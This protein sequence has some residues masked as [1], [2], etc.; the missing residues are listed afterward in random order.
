M[1]HIMRI[2]SISQI[3]EM[4]GYEKLK[5]PLITLLEPSKVKVIPVIQQKIVMS[6]Y[7]ISLKSGHECKIK[8]G[9]QNY[10]FQEGTLMCLAP[11]Q[12]IEPLSSSDSTELDGWVL[13]FHPD[14]IK[15]SALSKKMNEYTFFSYDS[16]EALHL[17]NQERRTVTD[18]VKAIKYEY[19]Q[20][21]DIYSQDLII[22]NLEL[23]L[24]HCKRFY[25]RQFVTRTNVN[26]DVVIRFE[27]FLKSYFDS[28]KP[29]TQGLPSVKYC[30]NV[31]CYSPN[32]LSDLLKKETGKNAQEHIHFYLIEKAKI[33]LLGTQEPVNSIAHSLGFEYPQHFSKLFKNKTG[34]LPSEYR[35]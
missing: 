21:L 27:K 2:E 19:S 8:Y 31:M 23:L 28:D 12:T 22:S 26:K 32:Y 29:K 3:N 6:L 30:A 1:A 7:S 34:M 4:V 24:N 15:K 33:M 16:H 14:L 5:H 10:D 20:N 9:R 25:S 35:N 13:I 17:S 11:G 18:I